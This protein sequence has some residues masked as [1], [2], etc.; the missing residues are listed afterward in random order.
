MVLSRINIMDFTIVQIIQC[1]HVAPAYMV[2]QT[3]WRKH[4]YANPSWVQR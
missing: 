2:P 1:R 4:D 3:V